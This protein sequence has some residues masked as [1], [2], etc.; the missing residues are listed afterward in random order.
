M[1]SM[2]PP[3]QE[4]QG[5]GN[6]SSGGR[7]GDPLGQVRHVPPRLAAPCVEQDGEVSGR[8]RAA[9]GEELHC[10]QVCKRP[11]PRPLPPPLE[12]PRPLPV[13]PLDLPLALP[14]LEAFHLSLPLLEPLPGGCEGVEGGLSLPLPPALPFPTVLF[15]P[16]ALLLPAPTP[17]LEAG[18][19]EFFAMT[20]ARSLG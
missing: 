19:K 17:P 9:Q 15:L 13:L 2:I 6:G 1:F 7:A 18:A 14:L 16:L 3:Q 8:H 20:S 11:F 5:P 4:L 10:H 12:L